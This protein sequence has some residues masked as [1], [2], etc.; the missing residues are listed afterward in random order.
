MSVSFGPFRIFQSASATMFDEI[1]LFPHLNPY[2]ALLHHLN[3]TM[4]QIINLQLKASSFVYTG[5]LVE[6]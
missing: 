2:Y 6:R 3:T 5:E 1:R 4:E